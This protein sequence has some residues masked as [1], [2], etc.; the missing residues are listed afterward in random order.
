MPPVPCSPQSARPR[1][2]RLSRLPPSLEG[3]AASVVRALW[4]AGATFRSLSPVRGVARRP[5]LGAVVRLVDRGGPARR[6]RAEIR[7]FA[8]HRRRAGA[9]DAFGETAHRW[10]VGTN[11]D[12]ARAAAITSAGLQPERTAGARARQNVADSRQ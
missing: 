10:S 1:P 4:P 8:A 7:W 5:P 9:R 12:S 11:S 2:A 6:P 3:G